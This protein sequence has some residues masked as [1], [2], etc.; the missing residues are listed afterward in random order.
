MNASGRFSGALLQRGTRFRTCSPEPHDHTATTCPCLVCM[1]NPAVHTMLWQVHRFKCCS[2]AVRQW[3]CMVAVFVLLRVPWFMSFEAMPSRCCFL[4]IR[5]TAKQP[6]SHC[7]AVTGESLGRTDS[8]ACYTE[9]VCNTRK[10]CVLQRNCRSRKYP[11]HTT[12][13]MRLLLGA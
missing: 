13:M 5:V 2:W 4:R 8:S 3:Q 12:M 7:S 10:L 6:V 9:T 11:P 1:A